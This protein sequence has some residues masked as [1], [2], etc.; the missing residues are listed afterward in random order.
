MVAYTA[1]LLHMLAQCRVAA[2][3]LIAL[4][5][6]EGLLASV[7]PEVDLVS[8]IIGKSCRYYV[9]TTNLFL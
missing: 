2:E 8:N 4:G 5:T 1:V 3:R 6:F 7:Q 9:S